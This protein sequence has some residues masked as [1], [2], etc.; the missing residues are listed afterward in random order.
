MIWTRI[1]ACVKLGTRAIPCLATVRE[2]EAG[3]RPLA[4]V[5]RRDP[6][7]GTGPVQ[8]LDMVR[9]ACPLF[10]T[11]VGRVASGVKLPLPRETHGTRTAGVDGDS[12]YLLSR[13]SIVSELNSK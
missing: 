9:A 6:G 13:A 3:H 2:L 1:N 4:P 10:L 11:S 12:S 7:L 8:G 5:A